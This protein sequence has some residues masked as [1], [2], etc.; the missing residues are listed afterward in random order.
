[1]IDLAEQKKNKLLELLT[2]DMIT[3]ENFKS[4]TANCDKE[5]QQAQKTI[6]K[7]EE[8]LF[9]KEEYRKRMSEIKTRLDSAVR[10]ASTGMITNEFVAQ[11]INKI[12]VTPMDESTAKLDIQIFTEKNT[13]KW[14][15]KL[16]ARHE[17][18]TGHMLKK[19]V[20]SYENSIK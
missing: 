2:T 10:D 7:L 18:R 17:V 9:T 4:M 16:R 14:L 6:T 5:A 20:E 13:Q 12:L 1:M 19:M 8:Q 11:Y 15:Q 3:A